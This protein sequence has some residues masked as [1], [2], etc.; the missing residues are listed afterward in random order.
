MPTEALTVQNLSGE[1]A[2]RLDTQ[3]GVDI[4]EWSQKQS[5]GRPGGITVVFLL[6]P[7]TIIVSDPHISS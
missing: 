4:G 2:G 1:V 3:E 6:K 5:R 7:S